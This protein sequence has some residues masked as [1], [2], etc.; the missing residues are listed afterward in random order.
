MLGPKGNLVS[1][2]SV[3]CDGGKRRLGWGCPAFCYGPGDSEA[4][5][6]VTAGTRAM[7]VAQ[8]RESFEQAASQMALECMFPR[9]CS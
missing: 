6:M 1:P 5:Y 7:E 2:A 4:W 3:L 9:F 8:R